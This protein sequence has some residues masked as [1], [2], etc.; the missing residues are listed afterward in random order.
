M[1]A[2]DRIEA[3]PPTWMQ[4]FIQQMTERGLAQAQATE[5]TQAQLQA[6]QQQTTAQNNRIEQ[7]EVLLQL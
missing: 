4:T 6:L 7:L 2:T 1:D 3:A 5:Q